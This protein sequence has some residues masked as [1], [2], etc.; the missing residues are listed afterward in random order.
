MIEIPPTHLQEQIGTGQGAAPGGGP[1]V[2]SYNNPGETGQPDFSGQDVP[3][4]TSQ[5]MPSGEQTGASRGAQ[6]RAS[7][8]EAVLSVKGAAGNVAANAAEVW[9]RVPERLKAV[10]VGAGRGALYGAIGNTP[11]A[12]GNKLAA[13]ARN[14]RGALVSTAEDALWGGITGARTAS[15]ELGVN[16]RHFDAGVRLGGMAANAMT[17]R[18]K[19]ARMRA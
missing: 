13:F 5:G 14:P 16:P 2:V 3:Q 8:T 15:V 12:R 6:L 11:A 19:T 17:Q 10:I 18:Y 9:Q 4:E 1:E 7:F